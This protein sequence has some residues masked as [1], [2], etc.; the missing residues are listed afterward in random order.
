METDIELCD[1]VAPAFA[2]AVPAL[3]RIYTAA[4]DP[5]PQQ[6]EGRTAIMRHHSRNPRF[7][8]VVAL[9]EGRAV[10]FAYGFRGGPG[11]WWYDVVTD[12]LRRRG[13]RAAAARWF[14][15]PFEVA[16]VHVHPDEQG[17]GIGRR[18]LERLTAERAER[19]AALST[20]VG[21][22][23]A[24]NLYRSCGFVEVLGE[25]RFPGSPD[26]PFSV[27]AA[28]LPLRGRGRRRSHDRSRA[29]PWTG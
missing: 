4:M 2:R 6:Y 17:R 28:R 24:R 12:E 20:H 9:R 14:S 13:R 18:V 7:H 22:S 27:M 15:D 3:M 25:F 19:T 10:G 26:Q 23:P 29:W 5:P 11:Q 16:E 1:L 21:P 8:S